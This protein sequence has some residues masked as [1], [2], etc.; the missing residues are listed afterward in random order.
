MIVRSGRQLAAK[1]RLGAGPPPGVDRLVSIAGQDEKGG[2]GP[3]GTHQLLLEA[4][5][6]LGLV[7]DQDPGVC[8]VAGGVVGQALPGLGQGR[9]DHAGEVHGVRLPQG[10]A[11]GFCELL[12]LL[13]QPLHPVAAEVVLS[14]K[15]VARALLG[16]AR[17][18][19]I[20]WGPDGLEH[21]PVGVLVVP[22]LEE[23]AVH[24]PGA[25]ELA[26]G[27]AVERPGLDQ[28]IVPEAACDLRGR[29][30]GQAGDEHRAP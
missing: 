25:L 26:E 8:G 3:P 5:A 27:V 21:A 29:G 2:L 24:H 4:G 14:Q 22:G 18:V 23:R 19:L 7:H 12:A 11:P 6:V 17:I 15:L 9:L 28:G 1:E 16:L 30:L 10:G 13:G 20:V